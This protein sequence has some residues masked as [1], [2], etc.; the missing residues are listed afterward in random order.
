MLVE[1]STHH[2][3]DTN[4]NFIYFLSTDSNDTT[5]W[6]DACGLCQEGCQESHKRSGCRACGHRNHG[7]NGLFTVMSDLTFSAHSLTKYNQ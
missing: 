4:F 3:I 6:Y 5:S 1:Q 7:K 2:V